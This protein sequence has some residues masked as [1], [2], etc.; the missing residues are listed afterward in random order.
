MPGGPPAAVSGALTAYFKE[1]FRRFMR[2]SPD[3]PAPLRPAH[4]AA[5]EALG[6]AMQLEPRKALTCL[7]APAV[8]TPLY[9]LDLQERQPRF[10]AR[11]DKA[12][13]AVT[14]HLL[15]ELSARFLLPEGPAVE[16]PEATVLASPDLGLR[17]LPPKGALGLGF[18][19]GCVSGLGQEANAYVRFSPE[20]MQSARGFG[21]ER[22]F[23]TLSGI[24][25]LALVD[26]NPIAEL[27]AHPQKSGNALDLGGRPLDEWVAALEAALELI[28]EHLP[29]L[30]DEMALLLRQVVPVGFHPERHLSASYGEAVG[31]VYLTLHPDPLTL[32]EA[33]IHEFQHNKLNIL[34]VQ[35][36]LLLNAFQPLYKSPVRP[37]PR[38]L[39]GILLA[40]HAFLPVAAF[41]RRL[42]DQGRALA[43]T[44]SFAGHL[45][46]IDLKN[47]EGMDVLHAHARWTQAGRTL[48]EDLLGLHRRHMAERAAQGLSLGARTAHE[49]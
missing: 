44:A 22:P 10:A 17:L 37:D 30:A 9:C 28:R 36:P 11:I 46:D 38:P 27:E 12:V 25:R 18:S 8:G 33:L 3:L 24:T 14:P 2:L 31:S 29:A 15:L 16:W 26:S 43:Q 47:R 49:A 21:V 45:E 42:R 40:V 41:C 4:R 20:G 35:D 1:T 13:R 34:A 5:S 39:W 23:R 19:R 7:S 48:W 32:A 6:R